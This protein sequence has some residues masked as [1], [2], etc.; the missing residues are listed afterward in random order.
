MEVKFSV[1]AGMALIA[2]CSQPAAGPVTTQ[3]RP[4]SPIDTGVT[5]TTTQPREDDVV[6]DEALQPLV[7]MAIEDLADRLDV[8]ASSIRVIS[9][10]LLMWPNQALGCPREGMQYPDVPVDGS[11][12]VLEAD[13]SRYPYHT[14]GNVYQ[15]FLC[16]NPSTG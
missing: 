14:G 5:A 9:A 16:E 2:A 10:E 8:D 11:R 1:V 3:E 13:G 12:I 6:Y 7:D 15:P 4:P